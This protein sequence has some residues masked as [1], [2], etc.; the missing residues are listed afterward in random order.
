[1]PTVSDAGPIISFSRANR[2]ELLRDVL[3]TLIIPSAVYNEIVTEGKPEAPMIRQQAWIKVQ[4]LQDQTLIAQLRPK[5]HI[6]ESEALALAWELSLPLL[7][8]EKEARKEAFRI[9]IQFFGSMRVLKEAKRQG[10]VEKIK[11]ILDELISSGTYI[12]SSL[13]REFLTR[14][15]ESPN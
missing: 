15:D 5:L 11:P 14:M 4:R 9:G 2:I 3:T 6:G 7:V 12:G 1:M 8:D 10:L 13:Y